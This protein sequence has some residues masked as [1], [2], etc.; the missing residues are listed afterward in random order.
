MKEGIGILHD[1][2]RAYEYAR[3]SKDVAE[4]QFEGEMMDSLQRM[5]RY[6]HRF[7]QMQAQVNYVVGLLEKV[8][9]KDEVIPEVIARLKMTIRIASNETEYWKETEKQG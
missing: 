1:F 5:E 4:L 6:D 9:K 2:K 3:E 8:E 7:D